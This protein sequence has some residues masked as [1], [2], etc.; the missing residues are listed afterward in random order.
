MVQK[1]A[2]A[3]ALLISALPAAG[4]NVDAGGQLYRA[5][6]FVCHGQEGESIPGVSFRSGQYRRAST[7]EEISRIILGGIPGTGMPPTNLNADER[8]NLVAYLR[9]MHST[10][11][12]AKGRVTRL[13]ERRFS[14]VKAA[15]ST[16]IAWR[17]GDPVWDRI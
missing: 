14:R 11:A 2:L 15:A 5:H 9:S 1:S 17:A 3:M 7:D 13:A 12:G 16:A 6:C 4:Q 10:G 8:R